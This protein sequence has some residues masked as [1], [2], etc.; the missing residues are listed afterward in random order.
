MCLLILGGTADGRK[1]AE[2][3]HQHNVPVI[4][5]VAGLVRQ[6]QVDCQVVSGGFSQFGGLERVGGVGRGEGRLR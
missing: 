6:P 3:F 4:Y 5:S 2:Y 1:L